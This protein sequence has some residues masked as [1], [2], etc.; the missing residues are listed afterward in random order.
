[1]AYVPSFGP[2]TIADE[3]ADPC[4]TFNQP[5][6]GLP[7]VEP[8]VQSTTFCR[9]SVGSTA[10][11]Q[12]SRVSNPTVSALE[13]TLGGL[14][15]ALPAVCFTSGLAAETALFLAVLRAGDHVVCG[16]NVYGGTTRLLQQILSGF[17]IEVAFVDATRPDS[18][19]AAIRSTTRL[20]LVET[21]SNP[22]L[23]LTDIA[24][25]ADIA[26]AHG[27]LLAVDNTFMTPV[28]QQPLKLGADISILS[29]TKFVEGHSL[30]MGGAL[31]TRD[32]ELDARIRFIRKSTGAIQTPFNA[33]LTLNGI[34]TLSLRMIEQSRSAARIAEWLV[35]HPDVERVY[36]PGQATGDAARI[37]QK[38]HVNAHG[39]VLSFDVRGGL[40]AA[41]DFVR[42]LR[43][44]R[45]VEH[46]GSVETLVTHS[47]TM[48]HAD[49]PSAQRLE[50]GI[51][52]GL[53]RL[54]IGLEPAE[55]IIDD[56]ERGFASIAKTGDTASHRQV[57]EKGGQPCPTIA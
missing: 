45:L 43:L 23:E 48:T 11:H 26:H 7:L 51:G 37:A 32:P 35:T 27:A 33:W 15:R 5:I 29:T 31:V 56:L 28:L 55:A 46:V 54:S 3:I 1:M 6:D 20:V 9:D 30:V 40:N 18:V 39:A 22:T 57:R 25:T 50:A 14:E 10:E 41:K 49:V 16:R 4:S 36:Y 44:C 38:Q 42:G 52:N 34:R 53:L 2:T 21:P 19:A 47:A 13:R 24:A 17:G 8:L 12:Y